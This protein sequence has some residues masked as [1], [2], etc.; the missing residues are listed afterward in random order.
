MYIN[1][2]Q[3]RGVVSFYRSFKM[4]MYIVLCLTCSDASPMNDHWLLQFCCPSHE[5]TLGTKPPTQ[6]V[7]VSSMQNYSF[8]II[9]EVRTHYLKYCTRFVPIVSC[10]TVMLYFLKNCSCH[11]VVLVRCLYS[12]FQFYKIFLCSYM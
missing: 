3:V 10:Y 12:Q 11:S 2:D 7:T 1:I 5:Q 8:Y 6:P 9:Q 4:Y